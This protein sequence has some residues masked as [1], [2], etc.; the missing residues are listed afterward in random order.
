MRACPLFFS[1]VM[2]GWLT[3]ASECGWGTVTLLPHLGSSDVAETL[4]MVERSFSRGLEKR[5]ERTD[6]QSWHAC[7]TVPLAAEF[8]GEQSAK[9]C[10]HQW[11]PEFCLHIADGADSP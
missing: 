8:A 4:S 9:A 1:V 3:G 11:Q 5:E 7:R 6:R 2:W 10:I